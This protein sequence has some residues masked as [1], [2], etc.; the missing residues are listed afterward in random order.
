MTMRDKFWL[1]IIVGKAVL[2]FTFGVFVLVLGS[3]AS[4]IVL[5]RG[6]EGL[7]AAA[8]AV[9][10]IAI[11]AWWIFRTLQTRC[12]MREARTVAIAFAA[13]SPVSSGT[14][15]LLGELAGGSAAQLLGSPFGLIGAYVGIA[16]MTTLLNFVVC[17]FTLRVT[18]GHC[19]PSM[20]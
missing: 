19:P 15:M 5:T 8:T 6:Q 1:F 3:L 9:P 18:R 11:A 17:L 2:I 20:R 14:S 4:K 7:L 12:T 10:P 16:V 13:F